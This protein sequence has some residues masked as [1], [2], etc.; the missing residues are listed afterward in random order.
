MDDES[1]LLNS[2]K[3]VYPTVLHM[4]NDYKDMRYDRRTGLLLTRRGA[5]LI[6]N[7][8]PVDHDYRPA[9]SEDR[10]TLGT[11]DRLANDVYRKYTAYMSSDEAINWAI[12]DNPRDIQAWRDA[13]RR[14]WLKFT[15]QKRKRRFADAIR[16]GAKKHNYRPAEDRRLCKIYRQKVLRH[17]SLEECRQ[18]CALCLVQL[19]HVI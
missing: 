19:R 12:D 5:V 7:K 8:D 9:A 3:D 1:K 13:R 17:R 14:L 11:E 18:V 2:M 4:E 10:F 6:G 16:E 15:R